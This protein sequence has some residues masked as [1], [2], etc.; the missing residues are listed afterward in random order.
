MRE[1]YA[2]NFKC[3]I[4]DVDMVKLFPD[5][6]DY[7]DIFAKTSIPK[8]TPEEIAAEYQDK[9]DNSDKA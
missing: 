3:D 1:C 6:T 7:T 4:K 8:H 2:L 9:L 5:S